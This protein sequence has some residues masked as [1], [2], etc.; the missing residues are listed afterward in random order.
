MLKASATLA[1]VPIDISV[2]VKVLVVVDI[3]VAAAP[4]GVAPRIAPRR[5]QSDSCGKPKRGPRHIAG[6]IVGVRWISRVG[7][8]AVHYGRIV[9]RHINDLRIGRLDL[10]NLFF[11]NDL[12]LFGGF[13]IPRSLGLGA[14][15]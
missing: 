9:C 13:E 11:D 14:Q 2:A 7:P 3:N 10:D 4:V 1:P 5:P 15:V 12:L 6:W 8:G